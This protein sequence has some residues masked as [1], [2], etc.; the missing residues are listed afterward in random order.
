[1]VKAAIVE[2]QKRSEKAVEEA[3]KQT[4]EELMEYISEQKRVSCSF[5]HNRVAHVTGAIA[6][7]SQCWTCKDIIISGSQWIQKITV[8]ISIN[9][10]HQYDWI[11]STAQEKWEPSSTPFTVELQQEYSSLTIG[12]VDLV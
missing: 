2:E 12:R 10:T 8:N 5:L 1:M 11:S 4:R 7:E 3:V 6:L 9:F